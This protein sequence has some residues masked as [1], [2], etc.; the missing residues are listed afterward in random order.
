LNAETGEQIWKRYTIPAPAVEQGKDARG[1]AQFGPSGAGIWSTLL[2]DSARSAL[3]FV[4]GNNYSTPGDENSDAIFA[5][6]LESGE[7]KWRTQTVPGDVWNGWA[8]FCQSTEDPP[9]TCK[10]QPTI[11]PDIDFTAPPLLARLN[12]GNH[13]LIAGRKDGATYG[14]DPDTGHILWT[15]RVS[16][17][18]D[19]YR[20]SLYFGMMADGQTVIVPTIGESGPH[21]AA[22]APTDDDGLYALDASTGKRL[23]VARVKD[24]CPKAVPCLGI[25]EAPIGFAGVAFAGSMDGYVRAYDTHSGHV[26]W[27]FDT[28]REFLAL[29]GESAKGGAVGGSGI[30]V[31]HGILYV[32]S[33]YRGA[34]GN[35]LLAFAADSKHR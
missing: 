3:Y 17:S 4:T 25:A 14:V 6:H 11:G 2:V 5:L 12:D 31:A 33:G 20:V 32:N 27:R 23:W 7:V 15:E 16:Q 30:M 35:V 9:A 26:L 34:P 10:N 24:D 13:V 28:A 21:F 29:N 22:V 8:A 19:P 1:K 18:P